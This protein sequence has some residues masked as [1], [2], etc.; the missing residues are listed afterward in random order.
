MPGI[1]LPVP[2]APGPGPWVDCSSMGVNPEGQL[3][4]TANANDLVDLE[5][6]A[7]PAA[8]LGKYL[9]SFKGE[10]PSRTITPDTAGTIAYGRAVRKAPPAGAMT[11]GLNLNLAASNLSTVGPRGPAGSLP[12]RATIFQPFGADPCEILPGSLGIA[13]VLTVLV[14][15]FY[16]I[17]VTFTAAFANQNYVV[18]GNWVLSAGGPFQPIGF[19]SLTGDGRLPNDVLIGFFDAGGPVNCNAAASYLMIGCDG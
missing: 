3:D 16:Q 1:S 10:S 11:P 2:N 4:E 17:R 18:L 13:S 8:V 6:A 19:N 9:C 15:G 7:F 14:N 5:T 12:V